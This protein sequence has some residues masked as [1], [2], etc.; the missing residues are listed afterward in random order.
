[1]K[2]PRIAH[3]GPPEGREDGGMEQGHVLGD[4]GLLLL[5]A[6]GGGIIAHLLRQPL[7]V[8]YILGGI[9]VSPFTPG[10]RVSNPH[11]FEIFA[12]IGVVLLMF[13]IGSEF[14][15]EELVRVRKVA[16]YTPGG[17]LLIILLVLVIGWPL[18]WPLPQRF[19]IG[20]SISVCS[21]MVLLKFLQDRGE[22]T[23][24]HGRAVVGI[25]LVEDLAS[26]AMLV[27]LTALTPGNRG[28]P[29]AA[30]QAVLKAVI[31]LGA[32]FW[33]GRRIIPG[34]LDRVTRTGD[35]ELLVLVIMALAVGTAALTAAAGL[36]IALGA[37]LAGLLVNE[38]ESGHDLL[39]R[40]LPIRDVFVAVF[41]ASVGL[42]VQPA[43][44]AAQIPTIAILVCLVIVGNFLIWRLIVGIAGYG[45][46]TAGLA[47]LSLTQIGEFSY[48]LAGTGLREG[49]ISDAVY[50]AVLATSLVTV[51]TNALLFRRTPK[52]LRS[53]LSPALHRSAKKRPGAV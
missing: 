46:K 4:L 43:L 26:V 8:G 27:L 15:L 51:T 19:V 32:V 22:V 48:V 6:L 25:A 9:V 37:F 36:S 24:L 3:P 40:V 12:D 53:W 45:G 21:T 7:I 35:T 16:L 41:F 13:S 49:L 39:A 34:L 47:A 44:L 2:V 38:S 42:L 23:S 18:R 30:I 33:L 20:A 17:M 1:M 50:Q 10:P 11:D 52:W 29:V 14:S 31:I 5:A 28:S